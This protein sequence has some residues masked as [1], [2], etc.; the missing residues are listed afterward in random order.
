MVVGVGQD[1]GAGTALSLDH[2]CFAAFMIVEGRARSA[3]G[4]IDFAGAL[5]AGRGMG[6]DVFGSRV[7]VPV[8]GWVGWRVALFVYLEASR[9]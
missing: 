2:G 1:K 6:R 5:G 7:L 8:S 3:F 4:V 9:F